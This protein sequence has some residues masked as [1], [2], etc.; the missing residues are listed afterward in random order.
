M[1]ELSTAANAKQMALV[2]KYAHHGARTFLTGLL[3]IYCQAI[4]N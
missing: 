2:V 1:F 3:C 4:S